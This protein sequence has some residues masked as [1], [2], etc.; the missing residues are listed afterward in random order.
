MGNRASMAIEDD[1]VKAI[2]E[3]SGCKFLTLTLFICLCLFLLYQFNVSLMNLIFIL[4]GKQFLQVKSSDF[5]HDLL[6]WT[7]MTMEHCLVK[8]L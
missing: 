1:E 4:R 7:K 2:Q 8:T 6:V 3:E 5:I